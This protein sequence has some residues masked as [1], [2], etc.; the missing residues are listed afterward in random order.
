M[1]HY[2]SMSMS[3]KIFSVLVST[4]VLSSAA[5]AVTLTSHDENTSMRNII[6][7]QTYEPPAFEAEGETAPAPG[8]D[9]QV[10]EITEMAFPEEPEFPAEDVQK[11]PVDL[12]GSTVQENDS[13]E[14][15]DVPVPNPSPSLP[16]DENATVEPDVFYDSAPLNVP[17]GAQ[18]TVPEKVDPMKDRASKIVK[19]EKN[20]NAGDKT[21]LLVSA[22]RAL[23]LGRYDSAIDL[24]DSL[25]KKNP[26]DPRVLMGRAVAYQKAGRV[27]SAIQSYEELLEIQ[28]S[29]VEAETSLLGLVRTRYPALALQRLLELNAKH[30]HNPDIAGQI[31]LTYADLGNL[32]DAVRYLGIAVSIEPN[33]ALNYYNLA[34]LYDR[35]RMYGDAIKMYEEALSKDTL[36]GG[37]RSVPRDAIY[38]RLASL[39]SR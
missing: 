11:Q 37:G 2:T 19:V 7:V 9:V 26:R 6:G 39:R 31:G 28:P 36:Y 32:E 15:T 4:C 27:Q 12:I 1:I 17:R 24:Y 35:N 23:D 8:A 33:T 5:H 16:G 13:T 10:E 3:K 20:Y 38:Q 34:V 22:K 30:P 18:P 21:S 25:Y 14:Y 29:N